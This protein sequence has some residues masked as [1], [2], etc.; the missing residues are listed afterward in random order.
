MGDHVRVLKLG[1]SL[2]PSAGAGIVSNGLDTATSSHE[3]P[4]AIPPSTGV[5]QTTRSA[6]RLRANQTASAE[7]AVRTRSHSSSDP[8]CPPQKAE[9]LY[10]IGSASLEWPATYASEKSSRANP[11]TS[12]SAATSVEQNDARSAFRAEWAR[13]R[14][15][16][17]AAAPPATSA[18]RRAREDER[19]AAELGHQCFR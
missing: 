13:R 15:P 17:Q 10:W 9:S 1:L 18:W 14:R 7:Y 6:A 19:R 8:S 5:T 11:T 16:S 2:F 3:N 4:S 12:T